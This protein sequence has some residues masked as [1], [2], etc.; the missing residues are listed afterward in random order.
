MHTSRRSL[1]GGSQEVHKSLSDSSYASSSHCQIWGHGLGIRASSW[2]E[3]PKAQKHGHLSPDYQWLDETLE[4]NPTYLMSVYKQ[5]I[6]TTSIMS[7]YCLW[8]SFLIIFFE[9]LVL[10]FMMSQSGHQS[11]F[12]YPFIV[13]T[14]MYFF[15]I[16]PSSFFCSFWNLQFLCTGCS[17]FVNN[18]GVFGKQTSFLIMTSCG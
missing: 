13:S 5:T 14:L 15:A 8:C 10:W 1:L 9:T 12:G 18:F 17:C 4:F 2:H 3:G 16:Y 6:R 11:T 7:G